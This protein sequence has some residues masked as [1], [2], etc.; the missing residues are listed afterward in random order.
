[1][2]DSFLQFLS[3]VKKS[4]NLLQGYNKCEEALNKSQIY[5]I[6]ISEDVSENT[7]NKFKVKCEKFNIPLIK[8]YDEFT[9]GSVLGRESMKV[10]AIKDKNMANKLLN[11]R[12]NNEK[13]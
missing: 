8:C 7:E 4:G 6:I 10:L 11:L 1:M 13:H 3:I 9:L 2:R 12:E 5:L